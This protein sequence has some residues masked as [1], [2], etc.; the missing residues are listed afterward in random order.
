MAAATESPTEISEPVEENVAV[1]LNEETAPVLLIEK[2]YSLSHKLTEFASS[3]KEQN[4]MY[5]VIEC[6]LPFVETVLPNEPISQ[7]LQN[8]PV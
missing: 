6:G 1:L 2:T 5:K 8:K 4:S 3:I 7:I